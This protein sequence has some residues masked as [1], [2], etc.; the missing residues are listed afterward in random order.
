MATRHTHPSD[1]LWRS[2]SRAFITVVQTGLPSINISAHGGRAGAADAVSVPPDTWPALTRA[3]QMFLLGANLP[4]PALL[5]HTSSPSAQ[6]TP[7]AAS[8]AAA[9]DAGSSATAYARSAADAYGQLGSSSSTNASGKGN[10]SASP[11]GPNSQCPTPLPLHAS[12]FLSSSTGGNSVPGMWDGSNTPHDYDAFSSF[13]SFTTAPG[14]PSE[15]ALADAELTTAVLDCLADTVL[16]ACQYAPTD[17]R[18]ALIGVIDA[19]AARPLTDEGGM[20]TM[21]RFSHVCLSKLYVLCC[22]GQDG[23]VSQQ[24]V[25]CQFEVAALALPVLLARAERVLAGFAASEVVDPPLP[26]HAAAQCAE[27]ARHVLELLSQLS[28]AP[29]VVDACVPGRRGIQPWLDLVR[30]RAGSGSGSGMGRRES[31]GR[32]QNGRSRGGSEGGEEGGFQTG[33]KEQTHLLVLYDV[34]CRCIGSPDA[35]IRALVRGI[36]LTIGQDLGLSRAGVVT[37]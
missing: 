8:L 10:A 31:G 18:V 4:Q 13:S 16:S 27:R 12:P 37:V 26:R 1:D 23:D 35:S 17:L 28:C 30:G 24:S 34:L 15:A 21:S 2:S 3:F 14:A 25:R 33:A 11:G 9:I 36:L 19:G 5:P 32:S 29:A 6:E 7:A 20:H 22:R